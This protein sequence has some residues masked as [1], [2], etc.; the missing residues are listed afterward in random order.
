MNSLS[1]SLLA[2]L[3]TY[4]IHSTVLLGVAW[5]VTRRRR[6]EPGASDLLWKVALLASLV[7][8]T[9]QSRLRLSTPAAMTLPVAAFPAAPTVAEPAI[10]P[11][12]AAPLGPRPEPP[13]PPPP[14]PSPP[15]PPLF[16]GPPPLLPVLLGAV[17]PPASPLFS[18]AGGLTLVARLAA[19]RA[20]SDGP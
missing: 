19:R 5:L 6:L 20:V 10:A 9:I 17:T 3:L 13:P 4:V 14:P 15:P 7:T 12:N 11:S 1:S 2:W 16:P 18:A 8:G